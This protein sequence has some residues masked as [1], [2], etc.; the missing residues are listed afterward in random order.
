MSTWRDHRILGQTPGT[1]TLLV[2]GVGLLAYEVYAVFSNGHADVI[3]RAWRAHTSRWMFLPV[4]MGVLM[5]HLNGPTITG[6]G[7]GL[8]G[9]WSP[10][11]LIVLGVVVL[12]RDF[13]IGTRFPAHW[14]FPLFILGLFL[15]LALWVGRP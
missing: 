14:V 7:S 11:A 8:A 10:V 13:F 9:R 5:G 15:G 1:F 4:G 2:A 6:V 12:A 3:T